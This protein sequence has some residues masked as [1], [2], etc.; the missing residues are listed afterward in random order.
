[1]DGE[2][3]VV[4]GYSVVEKRKVVVEDSLGAKKPHLLKPK[5]GPLPRFLHGAP[6]LKPNQLL[7]KH[8]VAEWVEA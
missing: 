8:K 6:M 4:V 7:R 5:P 3:V 1:V 2:E